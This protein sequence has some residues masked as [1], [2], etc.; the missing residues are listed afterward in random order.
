MENSPFA[1]D[2]YEGTTVS[3]EEVARHLC[4]SIEEVEATNCG[5]GA[6]LVNYQ[7]AISE[8]FTNEQH[9]ALW[10]GSEHGAYQWLEDASSYLPSADLCS[11]GW[12]LSATGYREGT[13]FPVIRRGDSFAINAEVV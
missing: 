9:A 2:P 5:T 10:H 1:Q 12:V 6:R 7:V 13:R 4:V 3:I 8:P 11:N